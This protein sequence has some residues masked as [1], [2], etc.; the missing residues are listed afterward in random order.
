MPKGGKGREQVVELET[1]LGQTKPVG[2][3]HAEESCYLQE[4]AG[5]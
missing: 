4:A 2:T 1:H 3:G 5:S